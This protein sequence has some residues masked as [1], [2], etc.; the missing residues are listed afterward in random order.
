MRSFS[1]SSHRRA[2]QPH[3]E[4]SRAVTAIE[5]PLIFDYRVFLGLERDIRG[6]RLLLW[7][8]S[9]LHSSSNTA[10]VLKDFIGVKLTHFTRSSPIMSN[11]KRAQVTG[12]P[13]RRDVFGALREA[14]IVT[15]KP[16]LPAGLWLDDLS[17][18]SR[19]SRLIHARDPLHDLGA[20]SAP[21]PH[22]IC[23]SLKADARNG[24]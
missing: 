21:R 4:A 6:K 10:E 2:V 3:H 5:R 1:K 14:Q 22:P 18:W 12:G 13:A 19:V 20:P 9:S 17:R 11:F 7:R 23:A 8:E 16:F 15:S 24:I